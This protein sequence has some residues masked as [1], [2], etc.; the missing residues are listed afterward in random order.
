MLELTTNAK[1]DLRKS[2]FPNSPLTSALNNEKKFY[3][4]VPA[5]PISQMLMAYNE[6]PLINRTKKIG[7]NSAMNSKVTSEFN[8]PVMDKMIHAQGDNEYDPK[9]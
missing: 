4:N 8:S 6:S 1:K 5:T 3:R 2:I 9:K 7:L